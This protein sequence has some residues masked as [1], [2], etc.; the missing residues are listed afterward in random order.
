MS[1]QI[2]KSLFNNLAQIIEQGKQQVVAQVNSVLTLTYWHV[3]KKINE[4]VLNK[5]RAEYGKEILLPVSAELVRNFGKSFE[6]KNLYRMMQFAELYPDVEIVVTLSRQLSWSH[7]VVIIPLKSNEQRAYYLAKISEERWSVRET[8]H[9]IER[10]AYE[11][12]EIANLQAHSELQDIRNTFKDPYF[13]DF[14]GLK[15][16]YLENDIEGAII[17][18]LELFILELRLCLCRAPE[19][20]H[21]RRQRFLSRPAVLSS[22]IEAFS[23]H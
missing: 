14:L 13:L 15:D 21:F 18:E 1:Q 22:K 19:A 9:Q 2:D 10:K 20:Y 6:M 3:G 5:E 7:F 17:K 11:R 8:R 4:H 16:G 12:N 23:S